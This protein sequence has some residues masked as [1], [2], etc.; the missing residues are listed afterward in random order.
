MSVLVAQLDRY[1]V[2]GIGYQHMRRRMG[3]E[4]IAK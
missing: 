4:I 1:L 3:E 2:I